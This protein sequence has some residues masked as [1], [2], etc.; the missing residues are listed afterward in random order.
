MGWIKTMKLYYALGIMLS[1]SIQSIFAQDISGK[2]KTVDDKSG[3]SRADVLI[4]KNENDTY[5]GK[6]L[7]IRPTPG[8]STT[9]VCTEC[10]GEFKNKSLVG[11]QIISHFVPNPKKADEYIDGKVFDPVSGNTYKGKIK[12][13][14]GGKRLILRGYLGTSLIGRNQTWIRVE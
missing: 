7:I 5:G 2:W 11:M 10:K 12:L 3:F 1:L 6:I 4:S 13:M 14:S 8:K 9:G